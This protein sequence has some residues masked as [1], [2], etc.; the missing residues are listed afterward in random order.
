MSRLAGGGSAGG[1]GIGSADGT[2]TSATFNNP[3]GVAVDTMGVVY[4]ADKLNNLI[5]KITT[6]GILLCIYYI[7]QY[8]CNVNPFFF[9]YLQGWCRGWLVVG[10]PL[11]WLVVMQMA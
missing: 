11:V 10:V 5:R 3:Y 9:L 6:A 1:T 4:V 2:G 8:M 7:S